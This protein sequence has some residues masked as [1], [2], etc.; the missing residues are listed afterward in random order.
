MPKL[1]KEK[2]LKIMES[3][4]GESAEVWPMLSD[5]EQHVVAQIA[6][7]LKGALECELELPHNSVSSGKIV[8]ALKLMG[9]DMVLDAAYFADLALTEEASELLDRL[10]SSAPLPMLRGCSPAWAKFVKDAYPDLLAHLP[11]SKSPPQLFGA[12]VKLNYSQGSCIDKTKISTVS[13]TPC[14]S[15]KLEA[16]QAETEGVQN[17]DFALTQQ[18]LARMIRILGIDLPNLPESPFDGVKDDGLKLDSGGNQKAGSAAL[19]KSLLHWVYE[20][21][22]GET[23]ESGEFKEEGQGI[24]GVELDLGGTTVKL[25]AVNGFDNARTVMDSIRKG[26]SDAAYVEIMD[27]TGTCNCNSSKKI[28]SL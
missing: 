18:E 25:L 11:T 1:T 17:L 10:E 3:Y 23:I 5:N 19:M 13:I 26:E 14:L 4:G 20:A 2:V 12:L 9:F 24:K 22:T 15:Q 28:P 6:P 16:R 21:Y 8:T 27:C 7:T